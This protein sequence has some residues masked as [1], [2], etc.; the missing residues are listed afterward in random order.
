M[1]VS[2]ADPEQFAEAV[3]VL[4]AAALRTD[5]ERIRAG[6]DAGNVLVAT[7]ARTGNETDQSTVLGALVCSDGEVTA[8]AVR[9]N[10]RGQGI[11]SAL[12]AEALR[13]EGRLVAEFDPRVRAFWESLGFEIDPVAGSERLRG[14]R[15]RSLE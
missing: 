11:G 2:E 1:R 3:S 12:V 14:V 8:V 4:D 13:R 6:I 10:R 9:P 7:A 15:D 5:A